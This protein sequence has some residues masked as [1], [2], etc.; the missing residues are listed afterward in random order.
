M[1]NRT[2]WIVIGLIAGMAYFAWRA[3]DPFLKASSA[4][5]EKRRRLSSDTNLFPQVV[6]E[7][8]RLSPPAGHGWGA[9][10]S[11]EPGTGFP[12][13]F[14]ELG[15]REI[16]SN[17]HGLNLNFG[18]GHIDMFGYIYQ[19]NPTNSEAWTLWWFERDGRIVRKLLEF[20]AR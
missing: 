15:A 18:G 3:L 8:S 9:W 16:Y 4:M 6:L 1:R 12:S 11:D 2:A 10:S 17:A 20:P 13:L 14:S 5:K 19:V 7:F